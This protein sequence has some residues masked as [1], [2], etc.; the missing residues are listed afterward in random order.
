MRKLPSSHRRK[1]SERTLC[2]LT[3]EKGTQIAVANDWISC[4]KC[5]QIHFDKT[6]IF[7]KRRK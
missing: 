3:I 2:G 7:S 1:D 4:K 6:S 5:R